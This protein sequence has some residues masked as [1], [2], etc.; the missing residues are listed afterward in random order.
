MATHLN[1]NLAPSRDPY[2]PAAMSVSPAASAVL[3]TG[4]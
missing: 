2:T 4:E 3:K 1:P